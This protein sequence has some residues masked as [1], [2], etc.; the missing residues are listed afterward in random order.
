[1]RNIVYERIL[2]FAFIGVSLTSPVNAEDCKGE[3]EVRGNQSVLALS[4]NSIATFSRMSVNVD[5]SGRAYH[6]DGYSSGAIIHLCNAGQVYLPDGTRFHGS[7]S[8][9]TCT[10]RFMDSV[11]AIGAAGW[12]N[13][14]VGAIR[15]YGI[16]GTQTAEIAGRTVNAVKPVFL[17]DGSGFFVS[18]TALVDHNFPIED[19]RRYVDALT[20]PHAVVR[21]NSDIPLGT[22][23]VAWRT[24][25]CQFGNFCVPVPFIVGDIGPKIGEGS[26]YLSRAVNGLDVTTNITRR[27]RYAGHVNNNDI[28]YVF[29]N[30]DRLQPPYD[31]KSVMN[32]A[33]LAFDEWGGVARLQTCVGSNVPDAQ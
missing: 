17:N 25:D 1:M 23:G 31:A 11:D 16:L 6:P 30:G 2:A 5:G 12:G 14:N 24:R 20:I 15:W 13:P 32:A 29:F 9:E 33:E 7:E 26:V 28:L 22:L 4:D 21:S 19:Q 10:G 27:N 3:V 18:P 8:N